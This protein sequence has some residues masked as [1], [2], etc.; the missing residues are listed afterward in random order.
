M[1]QWRRMGERGR[2]GMKMASVWLPVPACHGSAQLGPTGS[3][4][5]LELQL[6]RCLGLLPL[7]LQRKTGREREREGKSE[8]A[9]ERERERERARERERER[10]TEE[11][12]RDRESEK[13][14]LSLDQRWGTRAGELVFG[15]SWAKGDACWSDVWE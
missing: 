7:N 6:H 8:R 11:S 4:A 3:G 9:S 12:E 14:L 1:L 5:H 2:K 15:R 10:E 13:S